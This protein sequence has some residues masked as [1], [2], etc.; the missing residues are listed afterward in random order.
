MNKSDNIEFDDTFLARWAADELTLEELRQ[1]EKHPD[2]GI[3]AHI[4]EGSNQFTKEEINVDE[5]YSSLQ[6]KLKSG[7]KQQLNRRKMIMWLTA[8]AASLLLIIWFGLGGENLTTHQTAIGEREIIQLPD[9]STIELNADSKVAYNAKIFL[10]KRVIK[11]KGEAFF[12]VTSGAGFEVNC[13]NAKIKVLGTQFN[14]RN[15]GKQVEVACSEGRVE[16]IPFATSAPTILSAGQGLAVSENGDTEM[17]IPKNIAPW[18]NGRSTFHQTELKLVLTEFQKQYEI[19][20]DASNVNVRP[21]FTG[22]FVH[23]DLEKAAEMIFLPM[24]ISYQFSGNRLILSN[25]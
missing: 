23:R 8:S 6:I 5:T 25:N 9:G 11:L 13:K 2:Y 14:I 21:T 22:S 18:R 20:I 12:D 17:V 10:E 1:F 3:Y 19:D 16:V 7:K 15:L 4:L 24:D